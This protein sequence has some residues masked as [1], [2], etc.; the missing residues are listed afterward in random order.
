MNMILK[1]ITFTLLHSLLRTYMIVKV[2]NRTL[3]I[4][5]KNVKNTAIEFD[6]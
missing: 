1:K 4:L 5:I 2:Q 6:Y 3:I